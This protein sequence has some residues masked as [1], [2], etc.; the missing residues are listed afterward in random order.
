MHRP[1][2]RT[3]KRMEGIFPP[4]PVGQG[5]LCVWWEGT[6]GRGQVER[7]FSARLREEEK[8]KAEGRQ[9]GGP[10]GKTEKRVFAKG[11]K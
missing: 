8:R 5:K 2:G 9:R 7:L 3:W 6:E 1:Q 4:P 11:G 10:K